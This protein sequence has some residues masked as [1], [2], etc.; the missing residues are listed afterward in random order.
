MINSVKTLLATTLFGLLL[1][2]SARAAG[3]SVTKLVFHNCMHSTLTVNWDAYRYNIN[4]PW[5]PAV[6]R[7]KG[8]FTFTDNKSV[9]LHTNDDATGFF[10][11]GY[12]N[13]HVET[14][15]GPIWIIL[16]D[17]HSPNSTSF[18]WVYRGVAKVTPLVS[19]EGGFQIDID[20]P[21]NT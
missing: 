10:G 15:R 13:M 17:P 5:E 6:E 16:Y 1:V 4:A 19:S 3:D 2:S 20:C 14:P 12:M 9:D 21:W 11:D 8:S 7:P 18:P